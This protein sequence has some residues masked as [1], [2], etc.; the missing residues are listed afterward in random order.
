MAGKCQWCDVAA[1]VF[2][3]YA[4]LKLCRD[5]FKEYVV[6]RVRHTVERYDMIRDGERVLVALSGGKDSLVLLHVL[7]VMAN[8]SNPKLSLKCEVE[9]VTLDLGI[10]GYSEKC[11]SVARSYCEKLGVPHH[12][13]RLEELAG[14]TMDYVASRKG[15]PTC[16]VCGAVKRYIL[17]KF[18]VEMGFDR[19]A[20]GHNLDDEAAVLLSNYLSANVEFLVR[21]HPVLPSREGMIS[22][23]KPLFEVSE[24]ETTMYA[25][26]QGLVPV[27]GKCPYA[28]K[29]STHMFKKVLNTLEEEAPATKIRMVRGFL[30]KVKPLLEK[31]SVAPLRKC[32]VCGYPSSSE[33][34]SFCRIK[35]AY[36]PM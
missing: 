13:V 17:N 6:R 7:S 14:F 11:V 21:Q 36:G 16:S 10:K 35:K 27:D 15:R 26:F 24:S 23:I 9:A 22:R 32:T 19:L 12:V 8:S 2:L 18:G 29:P 3:P 30:E 31:T 33:V 5:H 34:C 28:T 4:R 25:Q 20:T 1:E